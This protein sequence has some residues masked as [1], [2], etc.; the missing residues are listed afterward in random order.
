MIDLLRPFRR[1]PTPPRPPAPDLSDV[2]T[3]IGVVLVSVGVS[4]VYIPA[5]VITAG[6]ILLF[7]AWVLDNS[8]PGGA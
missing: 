1:I 4:L 3:W 7:F 5:G 6:L 8:S 2:M